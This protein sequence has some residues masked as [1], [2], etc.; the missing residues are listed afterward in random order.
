MGKEKMKEGSEM[1][2]N[3]GGEGRGGGRKWKEEGGRG[4][5]RATGRDHTPVVVDLVVVVQS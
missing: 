4:G 3:E 1:E 2:L 5:E